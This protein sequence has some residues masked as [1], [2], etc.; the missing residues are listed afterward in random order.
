MSTI[1][2]VSKKLKPEQ[3]AIDPTEPI[4]PPVLISKQHH[5]SAESLGSSGASI[6]IIETIF[7]IILSAFTVQKDIFLLLTNRFFKASQIF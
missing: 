5:L 2:S 3:A 7:I 6:V 4:R 1:S